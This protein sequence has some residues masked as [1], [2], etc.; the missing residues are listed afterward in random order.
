[1][2]ELIRRKCFNFLNKPCLKSYNW[3]S[4]GQAVMHVEKLE[5]I[6][7][8]ILSL[9]VISSL[10][11]YLVGVFLLLSQG[12]FWLYKSCIAHLQHWITVCLLWPIPLRVRVTQESAFSLPYI[13]A[14][15]LSRTG[16]QLQIHTT[17][18]QLGLKP[19][20]VFSS[21]CPSQKNDS[22][23]LDFFM[24]QFNRNILLSLLPIFIRLGHAEIGF[25]I[26]RMRI[27]NLLLPPQG[28][29]IYS[30]ISSIHIFTRS[31]LGTLRHH[32]NQC[33]STSPVSSPLQHW[34][35][36]TANRSCAHSPCQ[37]DVGGGWLLRSLS[38][39]QN[40]CRGWSK[41]VLLLWP[42]FCHSYQS[43]FLNNNLLFP[44]L[45]PSLA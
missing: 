7:A 31:I 12:W 20:V 34:Q 41:I 43:V 38:P 21:T 32:H 4:P 26:P 6:S 22:S 18:E 35:C 9:L 30:G 2:Q 15:L 16:S 11:L 17:G 29:K 19:E 25:A 23:P 3:Q 42:W 40:P 37:V 5:G 33:S 44:V 27:N 28:S 10:V 14:K 8:L 1:M 39:A 13:P 36:S 45:K 24:F